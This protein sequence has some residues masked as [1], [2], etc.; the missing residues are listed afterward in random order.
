VEWVSIRTCQRQYCYSLHPEAIVYEP[1]GC[2]AKKVQ[3][4]ASH[5]GPSPITPFDD[6]GFATRFFD[7]LLSST[8]TPVIDPTGIT[9]SPTTVDYMFGLYSYILS[10]FT[11]DPPSSQSDR[12]ANIQ[13]VALGLTALT[14]TYFTA[15]QADVA[16]CRTF[17]DAYDKQHTPNCVHSAGQGAVYNPQYLIS[18]PWIIIDFIS[19]AILFLA[20]LFGAHLLR[21]TIAPDIFGYVSSLTRD[22][23]HFHQLAADRSTLSGLER[24]RLLGHMKIKIGDIEDG[25]QQVGRIDFCHVVDGNE[26]KRLQKE[27][28]YA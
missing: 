15:S 17:T 2:S 16:D 27:R 9:I 7:S 26:V 28:K 19:Y 25:Q 14:N 22:N 3:Y 11:S 5:S 6:D 1:S 4:T 21:K 13:N 24:A 20:A 12:D 23:P 10:G 8:G 18:T